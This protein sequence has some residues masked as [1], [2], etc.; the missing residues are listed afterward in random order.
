MGKSKGIS[1]DFFNFIK[2]AQIPSYIEPT[3]QTDFYMFRKIIHF[4]KIR[5]STV[6]YYPLTYRG[7]NE[8]LLVC[9]PKNIFPPHLSSHRGGPFFNMISEN[10]LFLWEM[11]KTATV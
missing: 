2:P 1:Q 9:F 4:C 6:G 8:V 5:R 10:I 7:K 3:K 11:T